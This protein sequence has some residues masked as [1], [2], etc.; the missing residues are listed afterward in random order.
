[1]DTSLTNESTV[2]N[3]TR[4]QEATRGTITGSVSHEFSGVHDTILDPTTQ[5]HAD[6]WHRNT[7]LHPDQAWNRTVLDP[8]TMSGL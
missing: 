1:M 7:Q 2:F 4:R 5:L 8:R 3:V 6:H